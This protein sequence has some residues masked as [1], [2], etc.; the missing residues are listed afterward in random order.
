MLIKITVIIKKPRV[1]MN[2]PTKGKKKSNIKKI[3]L[4]QRRQKEEVGIKK[5]WE[6]QKIQS[7]IT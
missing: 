2:K 1:K 5:R 6:K 7:S 4:I 3:Q